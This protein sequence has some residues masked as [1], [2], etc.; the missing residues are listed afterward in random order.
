MAEDPANEVE[1]REIPASEILDK[2]QKGEDVEYDHIRITDDLD[3]CNLD[4]PI[5]QVDRSEFV[6]NMPGISGIFEDC[7]VVSASIEITNS[8]FDG[9][10]KFLN[11]FFK[12]LINFE[13]TIFNESFLASG[14]TFRFGASFSGAKF[15]EFTSFNGATFDYACFSKAIFKKYAGFSETTFD[16]DA[17]FS[18]AIFNKYLGFHV[19]TFN[20]DANFSGAIFNG[21]NHLSGIRFAG[22]VLTFRNAIFNFPKFQEEACRKAKIELTK[23]GNRDEEEYHFY[24]EM[25]AKRIQKGIRGNSGLSLGY[26]LLKTDTWSFWRFVWYDVIEYCLV[27]GIFGYGVHPRR[28]IVSWF[29]VIALFSITYWAI[30][31]MKEGLLGT[32]NYIEGSFATAIAPGYIAVIINS[33]A[34][35]S[36]Y[37]KIA[38][39]ETIIGTFLW[40]GFI[41]TFA[42]RYMR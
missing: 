18:G 23:S 35:A 11:I 12:N 5:K 21:D 30:D 7:N 17:D 20:R 16:D 1:L 9:N 42:K 37:H 27:Q 4:L 10:V 28:V 36:I 31:G 24:R 33:T 13:N 15:N 6:R 26:L 41:A 38:I 32:L 2:I 3:I 14:A 19:A 40:A 39:L 29:S 34:Y 22:D 25:E 8:T